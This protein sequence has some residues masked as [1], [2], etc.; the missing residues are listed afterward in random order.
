MFIEWIQKFE[1]KSKL[2]YLDEAHF[3]PRHLNNGKAW[4]LKEKR[5][6]TRVNSLHEKSSSVTLIVSLNPESPLYYNLRVE[7]NDQVNLMFILNLTLY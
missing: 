1:D 3:V 6:Y 2:K 5:V 4:G 7:N